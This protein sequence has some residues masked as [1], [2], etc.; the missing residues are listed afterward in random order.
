MR[1]LTIANF[2]GGV[3]K[4]TTSINMAFILSTMGYNTLLIDADPQ[5][6]SSFFYSQYSESN[7]TL[8][9]VLENECSIKKAIRR[10]KYKNLDIIPSNMMLETLSGV[11]EDALL[12]KLREI[13]LKYDYAIID[14]QPSFQLN[15][16]N[17]LVAADDL[18]VPVKIDQ[19]GI[20][21]L[22]IMLDQ[23]G[24]VQ[25]YNPR[26]NFIGCLIT[27]Y[28]P[29]KSN[30]RGIMELV[31]NTQYPICET[32][33]RYSEAVNNS[34]FV[35]KPLLRHRKLANPTTDYKE[36]VIEYLKK[37]EVGYGA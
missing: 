11:K 6:N 14:C 27:M 15:T 19:F 31:N 16:I 24:E 36:L 5:G 25:Q 10:T 9:D 33:I 17:A 34:T 13:D 4:T 21:G 2:K 32:V 22:E 26:I 29:T 35:K 28:R 12:L 23:L 20:N 30:N 18:I 7:P 8:L 3:G 1:I 37:V